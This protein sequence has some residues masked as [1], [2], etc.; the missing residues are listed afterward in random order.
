VTYPEIRLFIDGAWVA[1]AGDPVLNP[2]NEEVIGEVPRV[3]PAQLEEAVSAA[4]RG[5]EIWKRTAPDKRAE[6]ILG[7]AQLLRTRARE[8]G[9]IITLEQGKPIADAEIDVWHSSTEGLYENQDPSQA[10]MNL[11]GKF[12]SDS[13]G[14][15]W[16]RTIKPAG[17]PIPINGPVGALLKAQ[18][19]HNMR[20][21]H[22]HFLIY[23]E[24]YKTHISQVYSPD[25]PFL[26]TDV[27]F[28][29]T[30]ALIAPYIKHAADEKAPADDV[31]GEWWSMDYTFNVDAGVAKLPR[32]PIQEKATSSDARPQYLPADRKPALAE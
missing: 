25:D 26:E 11:R 13:D 4:S 19:R 14:R 15:F 32:P 5:F 8:I 27:Q 30:K 3:T 9:E 20:P 12:T 10:D 24:G 7:A 17:Y 31:T 2:A 29:V 6:I 21:A 22:L 18:G 16:F 1:Q 23:K 28:G